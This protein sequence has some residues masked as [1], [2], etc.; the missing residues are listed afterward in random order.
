MW[1]YFFTKMSYPVHGKLFYFLYFNKRWLLTL[2]V[3]YVKLTPFS[4]NPY[5]D[6]NVKLIHSLLKNFETIVGKADIAYN[7]QIIHL[8][9]NKQLNSKIMLWFKYV[10]KLFVD[11]VKPSAVNVYSKFVCVSCNVFHAAFNHFGVITTFPG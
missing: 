10:H 8:T 5:P 11:I 9:E 1:I 2:N 6:T 3:F 7:E 4:L